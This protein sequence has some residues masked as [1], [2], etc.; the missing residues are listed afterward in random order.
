MP[1]SHEIKYV[2]ALLV[3][4]GIIYGS[5]LMIG[6]FIIPFLE[7]NT[8]NIIHYLGIIISTSF[9]SSQFESENHTS[10]MLLT[11]IRII[12]PIAW[13]LILIAIT[14][15]IRSKTSSLPSSKGFFGKQ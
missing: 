14:L 8:E 2:K 4:F 15:L 1:R 7:Q 9:N 5:I 10:Q 11:L 13:G 6:I 12:G 3:I